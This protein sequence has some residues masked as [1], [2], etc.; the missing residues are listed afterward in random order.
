MTSVHPA[1]DR[2][3]LAIRS[4]VAP[5][6]Q[7]FKAWTDP[8]HLARWWGPNGFTN[9][10]HEFDPRAGGAWRFVM[11]GPDGRDYPNESVFVE[12]VEPELVVLDHLS[13]PRFRLEA[14]FAED[15]GGTQVTFRQIFESAEMCE[16]LKTIVV[17]ANE[18]NL[19]RLEAEL[20]RMGEPEAAGS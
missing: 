14:D 5:R 7:V 11:H 16:R 4:V 9:T 2:E 19:D 10:F 8:V 18:Q 3:V 15:G 12:V 17:G 13:N 6:G 1:T 20:A